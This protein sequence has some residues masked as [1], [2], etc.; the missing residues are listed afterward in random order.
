MKGRRTNH[1]EDKN[2]LLLQNKT[3]IATVFYIPVSR[4]LKSN[5]LDPYNMSLVLE[6]ILVG[7]YFLQLKEPL[8]NRLH[9]CYILYSKNIPALTF[10]C[11]VIYLILKLQIRLKSSLYK[12]H[13]IH[14]LLQFKGG[15]GQQL[16]ST[17]GMTHFT[18]LIFISI[19]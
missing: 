14:N 2:M 15:T 1:R 8:E 19:P 12:I 6:F 3:K 7:C 4:K 16:L 11:F 10:I 17:Y 13:K 18:D 5:Y 9:Y